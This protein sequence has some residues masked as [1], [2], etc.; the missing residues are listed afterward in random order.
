LRRTDGRRRRRKQDDQPSA[1]NV[2]DYEI[3]VGEGSSMIGGD[4]ERITIE[5]EWGPEE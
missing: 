1:P 2:I 5:A 3:T 4:S